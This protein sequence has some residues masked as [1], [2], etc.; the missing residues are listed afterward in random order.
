MRQYERP[1][2]VCFTYRSRDVAMATDFIAKFGICVH[3]TERRLKT[4]CNIDILI[5]K[6]LWRYSSYILRKYNKNRSINP[7]DYE[8]NKSMFL[9]KTAKIGPAHQ[10]S[11]QLRDR[12]SLTFQRW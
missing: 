12:Y 9:D 5:L 2:P 7:K 4:T 8:D 6:Y 10:I 11:Q 1:R 3:S